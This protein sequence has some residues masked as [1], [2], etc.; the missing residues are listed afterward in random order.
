MGLIEF[1]G[2]LLRTVIRDKCVGMTV[3]YLVLSLEERDLLHVLPVS[4]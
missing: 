1:L 2:P 3:T 4:Y